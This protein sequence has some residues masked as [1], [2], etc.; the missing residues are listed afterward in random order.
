MAEWLS[1]VL[2]FCGLHGADALGAA[3]SSCPDLDG[4]LVRV[5]SMAQR[6]NR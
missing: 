5:G 2:F 6:L 1:P 4:K 3:A